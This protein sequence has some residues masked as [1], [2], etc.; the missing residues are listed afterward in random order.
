MELHELI[1]AILSACA[2]RDIK[3][4]DA[5]VAAKARATL[6]MHLGDAYP[7]NSG[8]GIGTPA[9]VAW[10]AVHPKDTAGSAQEGFYLVYLFASDGSTAYLSLN[11]GIENV[12]GGLNVLRKRA[13]DIRTAAN[14]ASSGASIDLQATATR[15]TKYAAASSFAIAYPRH[16]VPLTEELLTDLDTMIGYLAAVTE[17]GLRFPSNEEPIHPLFKWSATIK[18]ETIGLHQEVADR[19]GSVWWGKF[20]DAGISQAK[21]DRLSGQIASRI[22]THAY[23]RGNDGSFMRTRLLDVT[24]DPDVVDVRRMAGYYAKDDCGAFVLIT[25]F[26]P[27][28]AQWALDHLLLASDPNPDKLAGALS[29]QTT[30]LF[31]YERSI[32]AENLDSVASAPR[33]TPTGGSAPRLDELANQ[34]LWSREEVADLT[35]ALAYSSDGSGG[36][37]QVIL[38]GPPG[39]GKTWA[40]SHTALFIAAG[41]PDLVR[42]VQLHPSYGYEEFVE[43]VRPVARQGSVSFERVDGVVVE[44]AHEFADRDR[45]VLVVDE[46]NRA[47][48]P[49]VFGE[50]FYLLEYRDHK[51][52]LQYSKAFQLPAGFSMIGT[53]NTADRSIRSI[54]TALRRRFEIFDCP[55]SE[56]ILSRYQAMP[57]NRPQMTGLIEGFV[58]LNGRLTDELDRHHTIG[59]TFF[60]RRGFNTNDLRRVWNR[61]LRPLIEEYFFDQPD[62]AAKF[63]LDQF[64]PNAAAKN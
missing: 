14:L 31:V 9:E 51:I 53:M 17:S 16:A 24:N 20:G 5:L 7:L 42:T 26:E 39:T 54:D 12:K 30:P 41:D 50:L 52:D 18:A 37:G 28:N 59:H 36:L 27:L 64:W 1:E 46:L 58:A 60:M 6:R 43:G 33:A 2:K 25:D 23:L 56:Q 34:L 13:L 45:F 32:P 35:D 44:M 10:F 11:Q 21:V 29:N 15:P 62:L 4:R 38:A 63:T 8:T 61:Q 22:P 47:N 48:V 57:E 19:E 3:A 40:A 55:P 49:R